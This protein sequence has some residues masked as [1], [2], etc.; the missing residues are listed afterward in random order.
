MNRH[1]RRL[2]F[3]QSSLLALIVLLPS[4]AHAHVGIGLT[5]GWAHGFAHPISGLDHVCAMVA[6]GLLAAERGERAVWVVPLTF[7]TS[8]AF[9]ALLGM[10]AVSVPFVEQGVVM[11][12]LVLGVLVAAAVRLPL[13]AD[14]VIVMLFAVCHGH[15]HGTEMTTTALGVAYG[16]GFLAGTALLHA[17][18]I[19]IALLPRKIGEVRAARFAGAV[20]AVCGVY[21]Y[22]P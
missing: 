1:A 12:V 22:L 19:G 7:L 4:L 10:T 20:I 8:M 5:S 3:F 11:S 13:V 16:A 14:V 2:Q 6:I 15:V 9:G 17:V 21:L 18:G